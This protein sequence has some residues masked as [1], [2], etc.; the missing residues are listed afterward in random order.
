MSARWIIVLALPIAAAAALRV[1]LFRPLA[2]P[3]PAT[4]TVHTVLYAEPALR[5]LES[6]GTARP[7]KPWLTDLAAYQ[8][9]TGGRWIVGHSP[10]PCLTEAEAI[11]AARA[12]AAEPI[13]ALADSYSPWIRG[14]LAADVR[15]GQFQ[16]DCQTERFDRPYGTVWTASVLMDV[17][18]PV[19]AGN[20]RLYQWDVYERE[21]RIWLARA[22]AAAAFAA[23]W[24]FFVVFNTL[25]KGYFT[26]PL[27]FTAAA[28]NVAALVLLV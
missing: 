8:A 15:A 21:S 1:Y 6:G 18:E 12:D 5:S 14:C 27:W 9:Q 10:R 2:P 16:L 11:V 7:T 19:L 22:G 23:G 26:R 17:C 13:V 25:T 4:A 20:I 28:V 24:L 3:P